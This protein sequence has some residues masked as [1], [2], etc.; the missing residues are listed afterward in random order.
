MAVPGGTTRTLGDLVPGVI[1]ALQ[2]RTDVSTLVP[3]YMRKAIIELTESTTFEEL[4]R[5]GPQ[6]VLTPN[7]AIYPVAQFLNTNDD[8]SSPE[9]FVIYVDVPNNTVVNQVKYKTPAAIETISSSAVQGIPAW[10][11][12]FGT[13]FTFGPTPNAGYTVFLRYQVKYP[14]PGD[15]SLTS[16]N[17]V[18]LLMPES[19][20]EIVEYSTALRIAVVKRW[21]DQA[22]VLH[23]LLYGD[24]E[25]AVSEGKRGRPGLIA[26]RILQP[27]RDARFNSRSIGIT[28]GRYNGR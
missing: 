8:Y 13:T 17:A 27:E 28:V 18:P 1:E 26:A 23:D 3:K 14:F 9:V 25:Y 5:T 15:L 24:P 16:L 4:R 19:W 20:E 10:F 21:N 2:Q 11:T 7:Q 22:K 6:V 12:R